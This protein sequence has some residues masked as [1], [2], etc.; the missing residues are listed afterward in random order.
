MQD[1]DFELAVEGARLKRTVEV[2]Q[3]V[4]GAKQGEGEN[5]T[6]QYEQKW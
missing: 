4:Q 2:Y 1:D 5:A 3:W 6:Y